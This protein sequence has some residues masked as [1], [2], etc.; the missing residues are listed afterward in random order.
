M[1]EINVLGIM[2]PGWIIVPAGFLV[3]VTVLLLIKK[4]A[5][6]AIRRIAEK[7]HTHIDDIFIQAA[8]FPLTL[9]I[10]AGGGAIIERILP[11]ATNTDLTNFFFRTVGGAAGKKKFSVES[12]DPVDNLPLGALML[13]REYDEDTLEIFLETMGLAG[14]ISGHT[15]P[16]SKF[17][18][19]FGLKAFYGNLFAYLAS[20]L[21]M[22]AS[23]YYRFGFLML[24]MNQTLPRKS[25]GEIDWV[26][27]KDARGNPAIHIADPER[28]DRIEDLL[29]QDFGSSEE[30]YLT[31]SPEL[32]KVLYLLRGDMTREALVSHP[33]MTFAKSQIARFEKKNSRVPVEYL[34]QLRDI[35]GYG[36]HEV[37]GHWIFE[38]EGASLGERR[39]ERAKSFSLRAQSTELARGNLP[40]FHL[41]KILKP[42]DSRLTTGNSLG[43]NINTASRVEMKEAL[44][45]KSAQGID[46]RKSAPI[47]SLKIA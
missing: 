37:N 5:F 38:P 20:N 16:T 30:G 25:D 4:A 2:I 47:I 19:E 27:I 29:N 33:K 7:T 21:I 41:K 3:W 46:R 8:D 11:M 42:H 12:Y 17:V 34:R 18:S 36:L 10:F 14:L 45:P 24:G 26:N 22:D 32:R 23:T 28:V 39:S 43:L 31:S 6:G 35:V 40:I 44:I 15:P 9:L 13:S 1:S